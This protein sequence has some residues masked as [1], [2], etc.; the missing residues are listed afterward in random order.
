MCNLV[1]QNHPT[2][3]YNLSNLDLLG[4]INSEQA[5]PVSKIFTYDEQDA[6]K[7]TNNVRSE[8]S[9]ASL[10]K[11]CFKCLTTLALLVPRKVH[12]GEHDERSNNA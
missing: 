1:V 2:N 5:L 7:S 12:F 8:D 9:S 4:P 6:N 10:R 3:V 11:T